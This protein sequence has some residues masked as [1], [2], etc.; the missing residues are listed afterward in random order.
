MS[1]VTDVKVESVNGQKFSSEP[2]ASGRRGASS[3][4]PQ[5]NKPHDS[6]GETPGSS[7]RVSGSGKGVIPRANVDLSKVP[8]HHKSGD[9][10]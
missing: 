7:T 5:P 1:E 4:D 3:N 9:P 10:K 2:S 6:R 8:T